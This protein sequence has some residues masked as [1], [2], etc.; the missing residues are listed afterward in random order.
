MPAILIVHLIA[1]Q[2]LAYG[3]SSRHCHCQNPQDNSFHTWAF[4]FLEFL[5]FKDSVFLHLSI[6]A[7][8]PHCPVQDL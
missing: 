5:T 4:R 3:F 1:L 8:L 7:S 2:L 6:L